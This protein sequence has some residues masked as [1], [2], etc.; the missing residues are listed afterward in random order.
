MTVCADLEG[1]S[2]GP[3]P[4]PEKFKFMRVYRGENVRGG[5]PLPSKIRISLNDLIKLYQKYASEAPSGKLK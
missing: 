3:D 2:V 5:P 1:G 4:S